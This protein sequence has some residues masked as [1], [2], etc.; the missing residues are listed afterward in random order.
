[1]DD[2][3]V[4]PPQDVFLRIFRLSRSITLLFSINGII[5]DASD[6]ALLLLGCQREE[7]LGSYLSILPDA[8]PIENA[9]KSVAET[10]ETAVVAVQL[11]NGEVLL[12]LSMISLDLPQGGYILATQTSHT[13]SMVA[14]E[15]GMEKLAGEPN[16][17]QHRWQFALEGTQV[18]VWEWNIQNSEVYFSPRWKEILGY[19]DNELMNSIEQWQQRIHPDDYARV[20]KAHE[21]AFMEPDRLY[22]SEYRL[23]HRDGSY[24]WISSQG[25][26][27][28]WTGD[29]KPLRMIGTHADITERRVLEEQQEHLVRILEAT[30]DSV[31]IATPDGHMT[32]W[33]SH[34]RA[35]VGVSPEEDV[36]TISFDSFHP[37]ESL[38]TLNTIAIPFAIANGIWQGENII[39]NRQGKLTPVTQVIIAHRDNHGNL[40]Y[41]SSIMR[42]IS[43][44]KKVEE[45]LRNSEQRLWRLLESTPLGV[46]I[47]NTDGIIE[48]VNPAM[49]RK[50][51][52][53]YES[54]IGNSLTKFL[55]EESRRTWHQWF[56][57]FGSTPKKRSIKEWM[58]VRQNGE[59]FLAEMVS[60]IFTD[61]SGQWRMVTYVT[62]I[63]KRK[64]YEEELLRSLRQQEELNELKSTFVQ[65]VSHEFRT[66]LA[67]I[68]GSAEL[69][70]KYLERL[71][72]ERRTEHLETIL[73]GVQRM[74]FMMEEILSLGAID[75]GRT[76]F[77]PTCVDLKSM[78]RNLQAQLH[79]VFPGE[80]IRIKFDDIPT[81]AMLDESLLHHILTNLL[82][83]SL[84]Y[85][86]VTSPVYFSVFGSDSGLC[87][88]VT[89]FGQG[90]T[91]SDLEHLFEAFFRG[92]NASNIQGTGI[93]MMIVKRCLDLHG[94]TIHIES[95]LNRGSTFTV[96][97]PQNTKSITEE[98][99]HEPNSTDRR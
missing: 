36:T 66:P 55:P 22:R 45:A 78:C 59:I 58:L 42:D 18:G 37:P 17:S 47:I 46:V 10:R 48:W 13:P 70:K 23:Q 96:T 88:G 75:S 98:D 68:M 26:V 74:V 79:N 24:R 56:R 12:E 9:I 82:S 63:T 14:T 86:P 27:M 5:I 20:M 71:S 21:P 3:L 16:A 15:V 44:Q 85:S 95:T 43:P 73:G 51:D 87:F 77:N 52:Y 8:L 32:F 83:N 97:I 84:K 49:C 19:S 92:S 60:T 28:S 50:V 80:R 65:M 33:N 94:G 30:T 61:T 34:G 35:M 1:M 81:F 69:L 89:D 57:Q 53:P 11:P 90:I 6:G 54:L 39:I 76:S 29:K 38:K 72:P 25:K 31:N 41:L 4:S 64:R 93:G 99:S 7:L 67:G 40:E 2:T 91:E 62:D